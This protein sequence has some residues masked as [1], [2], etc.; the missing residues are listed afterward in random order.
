MET[1]L[2]MTI[3]EVAKVCG[4]PRTV[5][6]SWFDSGRLKGYLTHGPKGYGA[7][8][9]VPREYLIRFLRKHGMADV[10]KTLEEGPKDDK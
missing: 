5:A 9:R 3:G 7:D 4:V 10:A 1:Q 8:R 6:V 2:V